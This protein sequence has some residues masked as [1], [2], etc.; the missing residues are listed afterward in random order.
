MLLKPNLV[1]GHGHKGLACTHPVFVSAVAQWCLD[2]GAMVSIGDSPAFG[3]APSVMRAFGIA[4]A[5]RHL[6]VRLVHFNRGVPVTL[7]GGERLM[8]AAEALECDFLIN[9]PKIK[10]H[11]QTRV[12][13]A[14]KNYF[15]TVK[16]FRKALLHQKLGKEPKDFAR[17]L[18]D[19]LA[20]LPEGAS[21][22]DGVVAM[23]KSGPLDGEEH[24]LGVMGG[25][26]NPVALDTALLAVLGVDP[27]TSMVW[28]ETRRQSLVG[29]LGPHLEFPLLSPEQVAVE[30]FA[31][32]CSLKPV[33]FRLFRV[34]SSI[35]K[36]IRL[37]FS[38]NL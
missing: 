21:F 31:V 12:S 33:P 8:L 17:M 10:A 20:L 15:G 22:A 16:G 34:Y 25:A 28:Q 6:P 18:V 9:L 13:L 14:V 4:E 36:R 29:S 35:I 30:D 32:P 26:K 37:L 5:V 3:R 23:H 1:S 24:F 19:L 27:E 38:D 2:H 11:S 7:P